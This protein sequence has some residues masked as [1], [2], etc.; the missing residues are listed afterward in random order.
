MYMARRKQ[1]GRRK[2][3]VEGRVYRYIYNKKLKKYVKQKKKTGKIVDI[4]PPS[5]VP[6]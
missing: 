2:K 1:K 3:V 5:K 6:K 4:V